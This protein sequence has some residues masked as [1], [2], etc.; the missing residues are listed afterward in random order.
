MG[1]DDQAAEEEMVEAALEVRW[2]HPP[3][4]MGMGGSHNQ[5][6][7]RRKRG[8]Y[9]FACLFFGFC[10]CLLFKRNFP[11]L[12]FVFKKHIGD[13]VVNVRFVE[14]VSRLCILK[15]DQKSKSQKSESSEPV[16]GCQMPKENPV[17]FKSAQTNYI[18]VLRW[19]S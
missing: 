12:V 14:G 2:P 4:P 5:T 15:L 18:S 7:S 9:C 1:R 3:W 6:A 13:C 16:H 8:F 10:L 17:G 11:A 19:I